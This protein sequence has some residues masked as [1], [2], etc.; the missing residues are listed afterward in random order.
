MTLV[1]FV[2]EMKSIADSL[3]R[4]AEALE[5]MSPPAKFPARKEPHTEEDLVTLNNEILWNQ[6][7]EERF[8]MAT[9][10]GENAEN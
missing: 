1:N 6:E 10:Q 3:R 8:R 9:S 2:V 7:E 5:R 4:I